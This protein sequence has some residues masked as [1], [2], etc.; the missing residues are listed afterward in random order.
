MGEIVND[1]HL[2]DRAFFFWTWSTRNWG[3]A[4]SA[5][6]RR[7]SITGHPGEY[8]AGPLIGKHSQEVL[9]DELG[10]SRE[11]LTL[12]AESGII[13]ASRVR[14]KRRFNSTFPNSLKE[15]PRAGGPLSPQKR[16]RKSNGHAKGR[17]RDQ[18]Q[19]TGGQISLKRGLQ[20]SS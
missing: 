19:L 17:S 8:L 9:C 6:V 1:P 5:L 12:L 4:S 13:Y 10:M 20:D 16:A 3:G 11:E 15:L 7:P 2:A 14:V 18:K